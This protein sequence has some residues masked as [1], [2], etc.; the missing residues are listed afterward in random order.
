M[1]VALTTIFSRTSIMAVCGRSEFA[2]RPGLQSLLPLHKTED[3]TRQRPQP[4]PVGYLAIR[5]EEQPSSPHTSHIQERPLSISEQGKGIKVVGHRHP[6]T[7]GSSI[8][9]SILW[10]CRQAITQR[11]SVLNLHR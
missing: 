7:P 6:L 2:V 1:D 4:L 5:Q 8:V 9:T 3:S 11:H 10:L